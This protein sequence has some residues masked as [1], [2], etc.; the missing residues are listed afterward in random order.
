MWKRGI[1][2]AAI[3]LYVIVLGCVIWPGSAPAGKIGSGDT[4]SGTGAFLDS[5]AS[6]TFGKRVTKSALP[7]RGAG[8]QIQRL[9][10]MDRYKKSI[11]EIA[12][13]GCDTVSLVVDTRQENGS[14]AH[15]YLDLRM[16]PGVESL[17]DIIDH[18]KSKGL[19]V[20]LMPIVLLDEPRGSEWRGTINPT[21]DNGGWDEWFESYRGMITHFAWIAEKHKVDVLVVGS[22]LVSSEVKLDEWT[23]TISKVREVFKGMVTYSAN[24]DHYE[25]IPFWDQLDLVA[26]NSYYTLGP[27]RNVTVEEIKQRWSEI[28]RDLFAFQEKVGKPL[29]FTEVGWCS[30]ANAA[31]EPWDYTKTSEPIDLEL[32][33]KLY[34][35][36]F[37]SW[38][39]RP[40]LGGF[41][42]WEW[43]P[44]EGG[45]DDRGYTPENKP[46]EKVLREWLARPT[47]KVE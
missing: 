6:E 28:Q 39:G 37:E 30:L 46:A 32:Q 35:A 22:E 33:R 38:Y 45:P 44:E 14:S 43:T 42:V 26:F 21:D 40:E 31:H 17:G 7:F 18:A 24:W 41:I 36:F 3:A 2:A 1:I 9:D 13:V 5:A 25:S 8:M 15:I 47:W 29:M 10:W 12:D 27:N 34:Q 16:T 4:S 11:N 19:R 20:V 23:K